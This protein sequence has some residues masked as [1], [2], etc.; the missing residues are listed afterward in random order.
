[1]D[2]LKNTSPQQM[3]EDAFRALYQQ[4][5]EKE[6]SRVMAEDN[7][8]AYQIEWCDKFQETFS[9]VSQYGGRLVLHT[10]SDFAAKFYKTDKCC[11]SIVSESGGYCLEVHPPAPNEERCRCIENYTF[12][13]NRSLYLTLPEITAHIS[14]GLAA[15]N[16]DKKR[17]E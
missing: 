2:D 11:V 9:F 16:A 14:K 3:L 17:L 10:E 1:M 12:E 8:F 15:S 13:G 6:A 7:L 5:A 4:D